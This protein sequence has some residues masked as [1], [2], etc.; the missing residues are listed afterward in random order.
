MA[1]TDEE[2]LVADT[3][4]AFA[5]FYRRHARTVLGYFARRTHDPEAAA[6]LTAETFASALVARRR[7][8]PA[9]TPAI[10]WLYMIAS[11]RLIDHQRR[12]ALEQRT[13]EALTS[14]TILAPHQRPR[15]RP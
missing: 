6:D 3:P 5:E 1:K 4:E 8:Q 14:A 13:R 7:F 10:G 12:A 15:S 9:D 11:R 2:L